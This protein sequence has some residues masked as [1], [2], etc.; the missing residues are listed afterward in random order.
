MSM[1][2]KPKVKREDIL[3]AAFAVVRESGIEQLNV[4]RIASELGCSTQPVM[5]HF[6]TM[7]LLKEAVYE[8]ADQFHTEYLLRQR[9]ES[10]SPFLSIGMNHI[11][12]AR[13]E[14]PLF[15][16]L[17]QSAFSPHQ[18]LNETFDSDELAPL[19]SALQ[20]E[21]ALDIQQAKTVFM[22][23]AMVTH[24]YAS[25]LSNHLLEYSEEFVTSQLSSV[26][27]GAIFVAQEGHNEKTVRQK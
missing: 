4:R 1:P 23:L 19:L 3:D 8:R 5:Y 15:R 11:R 7:D 25:L 20:T 14:A 12:F 26:F 10:G 9:G 27:N 24:G 16:F 2:P 13:E 18:S 21:T 6:Q 17:F 22:S